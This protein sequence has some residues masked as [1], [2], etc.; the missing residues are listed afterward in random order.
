MTTARAA[1]LA[2][3]TLFALVPA[4]QAG[5]IVLKLTSKANPS[6]TKTYDLDQ[7]ETLGLTKFVTT[8]SWTDGETSFEGVKLSDLLAANNLTGSVLKATAIN[9]Y[10]ADI[11][12]GDTEKYPV[13]IATKMDG[14]RM[15]V[16]D[17]GPLWIVYPRRDFPEL[18]DEGHNFKWIWQLSSIE[19]R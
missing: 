11:P 12:F 6:F 7:L 17:K 14:K 18:M 13:M 16:R 8:T 3:M 1:L 19:V 4:A 10:A 15:A 5:D 9:D 2:L